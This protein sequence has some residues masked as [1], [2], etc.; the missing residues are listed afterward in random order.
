MSN[1]GAGGI[2]TSLIDDTTAG[3]VTLADL[4]AATFD[5]ASFISDTATYATYNVT[6]HLAAEEARRS[7]ELAEQI[8][9]LTT[10]LDTI[11][12]ANQREENSGST[13][14]L[15]EIPPRVARARE[16]TEKLTQLKAERDP[17][18]ARVQAS[19]L[20]FSF[21]CTGREMQKTISDRISKMIEQHTADRQVN[22]DNVESTAAELSRDPQNLIEQTVVLMQE[23]TTKVTNASGAHY[24]RE[25]LTTDVLRKLLDTLSLN[26][27]SR[28][29]QSLALAVT[30]AQDYERA[31]DAG[32]PRRRPGP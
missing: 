7:V 19:A 23:M 13:L 26:E 22:P 5:L 1:T 24:P 12:E 31:V 4:D 6:V 27:I 14:S 29:N 32:F 11:N 8:D 9:T 17:L 25:K 30:G 2:D 21:A 10:E 3:G 15:G 20:T 28:I 16:L 18:V